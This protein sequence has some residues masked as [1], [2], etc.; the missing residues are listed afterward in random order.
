MRT[1]PADGCSTFGTEPDIK[2]GIV[3]YDPKNTNDP[4]SSQDKFPTAC[5]DEPYESL[6]PKL[7][8]TVGSP[9]NEEGKFSFRGTVVLY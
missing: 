4:T 1:I 3:R 8:W 5:S 2:T 6:V 7:H 9:A